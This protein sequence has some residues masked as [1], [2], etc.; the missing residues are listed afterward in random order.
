[1]RIGVPKEIKNEERR[2]ALT[3]GGVADLVNRG[4][5][6]LVE[7]DAGAGAG[8]TDEEYVAHGA[9]HRRPSAEAVFDQADMIVKVKEPQAEERARLRG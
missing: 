4:H 5:D 3:P 8:F 1:M 2:V 9:V 7:R 6:V